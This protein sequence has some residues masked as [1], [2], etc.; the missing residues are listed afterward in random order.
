M[1]F[2]VVKN[3]KSMSTFMTPWGG[4]IGT[5]IEVTRTELKLN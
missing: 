4:N 5:E 2:C 3:N 1:A